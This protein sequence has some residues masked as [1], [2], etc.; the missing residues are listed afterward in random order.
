VLRSATPAPAEW[1]A[2]AHQEGLAVQTTVSFNSMLF[3]GDTLQLASIRAVPED[4]PSTASWSSPPARPGAR[5][6]LALR[7]GDA[8]ARRQGGE[9]LEVGN[10]RLTVAGELGQEPDQGFSPF[11][12]APRAL[13]HSAD[14]E[15]TG[16]LLP[17][18]RQQWRYLVKGPRDAIARYEPGSTPG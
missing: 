7:Q 15:A 1:L 3:H 8:A 6:D 4:F 9:V 13:I 12:M 11:Q 16:A 2:Q 14:I 18:S 10:T 17:G 5:R